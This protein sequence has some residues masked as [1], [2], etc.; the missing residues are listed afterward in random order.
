MDIQTVVALIVVFVVVD[1][2]FWF[3]TKGKN[4]G[5]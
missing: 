1:V 2:A 4:N 3:I 5:K